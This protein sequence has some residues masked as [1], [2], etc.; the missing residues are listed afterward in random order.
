MLKKYTSRPGTLVKAGAGLGLLLLL[1]LIHCC[2]PGFFLHSF[3]LAISGDIQGLAEYLRSYGL[4]ALLISFLLDVLINA[5]GI[6]PS[7][8]LSAANGL[9]FGLPLGITLSWLA[10]TTGVVVSFFLMRYF[11]RDAAELVIAKSNYLQSIDAASGRYGLLWMMGARAMP[12]FPSGIL[13]AVGAVSSI[14]ARDYIIANL[15]GKFPSTA[16]EVVVGHDVLSLEEHKLRL[17]LDLLAVVILLLACW[18]WRR[19]LGKAAEPQ[20]ERR[21]E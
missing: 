1:L 17:A 8:F 19:R 2:A 21:E 6:F 13:T 12:Y 10:E 14:S 15:V 20:Q 9:V 3:D 11:F 5:A 18:W 4:W 16:L 7:I